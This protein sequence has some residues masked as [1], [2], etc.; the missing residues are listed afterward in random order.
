MTHEGFKLTQHFKD[1]E[2]LYFRARKCFDIFPEQT[3]GGVRIEVCEAAVPN[4][5][6]PSLCELW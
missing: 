2:Y 5:R 4:L 6:H 1:D 3:V